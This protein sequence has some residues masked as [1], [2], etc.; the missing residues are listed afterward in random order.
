MAL[1][2]FCPKAGAGLDAT[3]ML[4]RLLRGPSWYT[5]S[6]IRVNA[7]E[8][9]VVIRSWALESSDGTRDPRPSRRVHAKEGRGLGGEPATR[10]RARNCPCSSSDER[11]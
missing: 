10:P 7:I 6:V 4:P 3:D 8:A 5:S 9:G 2:D 1:E 11:Q